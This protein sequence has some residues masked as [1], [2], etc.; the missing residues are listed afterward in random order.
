MLKQREDKSLPVP[1]V[2]GI[3]VERGVLA[4]P[5]S[6]FVILE[7]F[8][9]VKPGTIRKCR[10]N[11]LLTTDPAAAA[12]VAF[13]DFQTTANGAE[14]TVYVAANGFLYISGMTADPITLNFKASLTAGVQLEEAPFLVSLPFPNESF[15]DF[16]Q[17]CIITLGS[18]AEIQKF[19]GVDVTRL[20]IENPTDTWDVLYKHSAAIPQN[21]YTNVEA[22]VIFQYTTPNPAQGVPVT[23]GRR[24]R[25]SWFNP[26][27]K[28]D[29]SLAALHQ[30]QFVVDTLL[31]PSAVAIPIKN[32]A[33]GTVITAQNAPFVM[34][35]PIFL[36]NKPNSYTFEDIPP[37]DAGYTK[38]R[39]WAT[40][41]GQVEYFLVPRL[42]DY[43]GVVITDED[44]A[45]NLTDLKYGIEN[46]TGNVGVHKCV[47]DGFIP[48]YSESLSAPVE[49]NVVQKYNV[50]GGAVGTPTLAVTHDTGVNPTPFRRAQFMLP[51]DPT[52]YAIT[53]QSGGGPNYAWTISPVLAKAAVG[54]DD[55]LFL[56][57]QP[58]ADSSLVDPF[59]EST[60]LNSDRENDPPPK[61]SWGVVYN[62]RLYVLPA[63]DKTQLRYSRIGRYE[64]F[65]PDNVFR[66]IQADYD[67][68]T[69]LLAGRQVG[70]V[71]EG[72]DQ[73][74][75]VGK[76]R[77]TA[78]ITGT[79]IS[80][81]TLGPLFPETGIVHKRAAI[82]LSGSVVALTR[83]GIELL[84]E[85]RPAFIG[86]SIKDI[87][88]RIHYMD[89]FGPC[90]AI[91][92]RDNVLLLG[93]DL[94]PPDDLLTVQINNIIM[95]RE[96]RFG[97]DGVLESPYSILTAIPGGALGCLFESGF[98]PDIRILAGADDGNV[99]QLFTGGLN[100]ATPVIAR[101]QT[102]PL[103]QD[104]IDQRKVF[105]T[106]RLDGNNI[107]DDDGWFVRFS[108][109]DGAAGTWTELRR[110][111]RETL[112]GLVGKQ[113][114]IEISHQH[115]VEVG[116]DAPQISNFKLIYTNVG[117]G[118]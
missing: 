10:G 102:Q 47:F 54:G 78:A 60:G 28:H 116:V 91:D 69:A 99:Y 79:D 9:L 89:P 41:D 6:S 3:N 14:I 70:L 58:T 103:P 86:T 33:A 24:Y 109:D 45:V 80:N 34:A 55:V 18:L 53:A 90:F 105:H 112:I 96:P 71:S 7:N 97:Q 110:L 48:R 26:T 1:S 83:R 85:Q 32:K 94:N 118:R 72:A 100:G 51:G 12:I 64:S 42:Y 16:V 31:S 35:V 104:D 62:N 27:T 5:F 84:E 95:M 56:F 36:D 106:L 17:Y 57:T 21:L 92:R 8:D 107:N 4:R 114:T 30:E 23:I 113:L 117:E 75:V 49:Y 65:P 25:W 15:T 74:L 76:P 87:T 111:Y 52:V 101:A 22:G 93:V 67:P 68:I 46:F 43:D 59:A 115:E 39:F 11:K 44:S 73:R 37:P 108:T 40:R 82:V 38:I 19:D 88:D 13:R 63:E 61:A 77:S 81:F 20:G 50:I 66:F 98:G 2:Q 29:S